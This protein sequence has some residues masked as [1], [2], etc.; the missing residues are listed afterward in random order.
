MRTKRPRESAGFT[1]IEAV[2]VIAVMGLLI[3]LLL[4]AV[5]SAR[6]SSRRLQCVNNLKQIGVAMNSHH[7]SN[8]RFPPGY[9]TDLFASGRDQWSPQTGWGVNLLSSL[10]QVPLYNA[11]NFDMTF[12]FPMNSTAREAVLSV[13]LCPS[14]DAGGPVYF[15]PDLVAW[16]P[17]QVARNVA[18]S[19]Y[20]ASSGW[21]PN[22]SLGQEADGVFYHNSRTSVQEI[23]DGTS[24][25]LFV[26]ER[27]RNLADATWV[28]PLY[29]PVG[30]FC[31]NPA[32]PVKKCTSTCML[33]LGWPAPPNSQ[34]SGPDGFF[35][36]HPGGCNF[37]FGDGSVRFIKQTITAA[38]FTSLSTRAGGELVSSDQL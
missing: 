34:E 32:W 11:V 17:P 7:S 20:V 22:G 15:D 27:S 18:S 38:V 14:S 9:Q 37:L 25:T 19:Q 8:R 21:F 36:R 6:E 3:A 10:G 12:Q 2:V 35:S 26:G 28:G 33:V 23:T 31:T 4:P 24:T 16:D 1:L 5:Q 13:F 29:L 30:Q